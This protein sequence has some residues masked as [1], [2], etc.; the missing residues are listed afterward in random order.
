MWVLIVAPLRAASTV[1]VWQSV[2]HLCDASILALMFH[3][4]IGDTWNTV[5][6]VE[7]RLGAAVLGVLCVWASALLAAYTYYQAVPFAGE[8][9]VP[10][11][12]WITVAGTLIADTWRVN[13]TAGDEPLYP[14]KGAVNT[15]F[16]F[17]AE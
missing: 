12:L 17:A 5:N 6:N 14:Y 3:L 9:L 15:K 16:W 2:G 7:R 11:C 8:L 4:C 10:M 13:N 1:L